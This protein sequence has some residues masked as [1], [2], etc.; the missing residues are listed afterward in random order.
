[1][2]FPFAKSKGKIMSLT[3]HG[4][5]TAK[6]RNMKLTIIFGAEALPAIAIRIWKEE[7]QVLSRT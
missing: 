3:Q 4:S 5:Q 1:V 7:A 6:K 2:F